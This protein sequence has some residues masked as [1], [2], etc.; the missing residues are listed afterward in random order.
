M[1]VE[2]HANANN[3]DHEAINHSEYSNTAYLDDC[4]F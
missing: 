4:N 3:A 2:K 1:D